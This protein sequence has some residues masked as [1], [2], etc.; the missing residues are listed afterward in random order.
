[1]ELVLFKDDRRQRVGRATVA[2]KFEQFLLSCFG[3]VASFEFK[4][5]G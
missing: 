2:V 5:G 1:M 3:S 4:F